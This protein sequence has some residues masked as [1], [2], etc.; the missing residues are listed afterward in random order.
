MISGATIAA[1]GAQKIDD[2]LDAR[3]RSS[4]EVRKTVLCDD[5]IALPLT[6]PRHTGE[7]DLA[8]KEVH[9]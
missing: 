2:V 9:V 4:P 7:S 1:L 8:V 3:E 5:G 6:I